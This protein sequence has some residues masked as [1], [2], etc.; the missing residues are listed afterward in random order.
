MHCILLSP[1][2]WEFE[3]PRRKKSCPG[4]DNPIDIQRNVVSVFGHFAAFLMSIA[5]ILGLFTGFYFLSIS[6]ETAVVM[7]DLTAFFI[8]SYVFCVY[9][10]ME[11]LLSENLRESFARMSWRPVVFQ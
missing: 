6:D 7:R 8:P 3:N 11:T 5:Q 9:P 1:N 10:L 2:E 4:E